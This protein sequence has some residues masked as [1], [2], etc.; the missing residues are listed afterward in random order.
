MCSYST[1]PNALRFAC[2]SHRNSSDLLANKIREKKNEDR[3]EEGE[4][5]MLR[6]GLEEAGELEFAQT[7]N[8]GDN[9]EQ[10]VSVC[11]HSTSELDLSQSYLKTQ[12]FINS[13]DPFENGDHKD[14]H[15]RWSKWKKVMMEKNQ[16][17]VD[18]IQKL[19]IS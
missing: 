18:S 6:S 3:H 11:D 17:E 2:A 16:E 9:N 12:N 5:D 1:S 19:I 14:G 4:G 13:D 7:I 8:A 15:I 10:K